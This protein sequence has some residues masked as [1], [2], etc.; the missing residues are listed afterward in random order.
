MYTFFMNFQIGAVAVEAEGEETEEGAAGVVT[1]PKAAGV[2]NRAEVKT[3]ADGV[4]EVRAED[5]VD[6][7]EGAGCLAAVRTLCPVTNNSRRPCLE[8]VEGSSSIN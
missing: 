5:G 3:R 6:S 4:R 8:E 2:A 1:R 7:R